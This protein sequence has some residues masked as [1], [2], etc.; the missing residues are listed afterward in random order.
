MLL[1][2]I[3]Y[4]HFCPH[5]QI[6]INAS[7]MRKKKVVLVYSLVIRL[8]DVRRVAEHTMALTEMNSALTYI[9]MSSDHMLPDSKQSLNSARPPQLAANAPVN[10]KLL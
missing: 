4:V 8:I 7:V 9:V 5:L 3:A 1:L 10:Q 6:P 2:K